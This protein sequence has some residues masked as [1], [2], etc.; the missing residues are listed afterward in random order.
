MVHDILL[1]KKN[2]PKRNPQPKFKNQQLIIKQPKILKKKPKSWPKQQL[3]NTWIKKKEN[4][5]TI[6][7]VNIDNP[8]VQKKEKRNQNQEH[9]S[10]KRT[11]NYY[12]RYE[13]Q[14]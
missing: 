1:N 3:S 7:F 10:R 6:I 5:W 14:V 13:N 9:N 2:Y 12:T 4:G 8:P 11:G